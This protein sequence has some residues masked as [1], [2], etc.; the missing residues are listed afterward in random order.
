M[1]VCTQCQGGKITQGIEDVLTDAGGTQIM[2]DAPAPVPCSQ[3]NG[4]GIM[5]SFGV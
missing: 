3:C 5:T 4:T 1:T 2:R